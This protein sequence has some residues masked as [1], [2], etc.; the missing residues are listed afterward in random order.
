MSVAAAGIGSAVYNLP[1]VLTPTQASSSQRIQLLELLK[2]N[3]FCP[4]NVDNV[5]PIVAGDTTDSLLGS[6]IEVAVGSHE[7]LLDVDDDD[8]ILYDELRTVATTYTTG[9][10]T[11]HSLAWA[12]QQK[13]QVYTKDFT[14]GA[15]HGILI[16]APTLSFLGSQAGASNEEWVLEIEYRLKYVP[17]SEL[18]GLVLQQFAS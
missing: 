3:V 1:V 2:A 18:L 7:T 13:S 17:Q 8:L 11:N 4:V 10:P 12:W 15:G 16:A 9:T 14:D 6:V 5:S